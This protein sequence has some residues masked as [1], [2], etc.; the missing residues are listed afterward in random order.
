MSEVEIHDVR[1]GVFVQGRGLRDW[2]WNSVERLQ[3]AGATCLF[4]LSPPDRLPRRICIAR[5]LDRLVQSVLGVGKDCRMQ[6]EES[7]Q[8]HY[9]PSRTCVVE[10]TAEGA[11]ALSSEQR[12]RLLDRRLKFILFF[13]A[14]EVPEGLAGCAE[15]G[16]WRFTQS[17]AAKDYPFIHGLCR[18][19]DVVSF[20]LE[21]IAQHQGA[22]RPLLNGH[23]RARGER[24]RSVATQVLSEAARW[25]LRVLKHVLLNRNLP[26]P[27]GSGG[28]DAEPT[29]SLALIPS[30]LFRDLLVQMASK[31]T[32]YFVLETWTIGLVRMNF[33]A[34]L[35]GALP[36]QVTLLPRPELGRYIADPFI[37]STTPELTFLVEDYT[38]FEG[39]RISEVRVR[40]P[41]GIPQV[42]LKVCLQSR[43]H[44]SYPFLFR[45]NG[46]TYCLP[47][48]HQSLASV[49][50][51]YDAGEFAAVADL[52]PGA[53][54]TDA[55]I[56]VHEGLYW[57]F[58][59][60]ADDNDQANLHLFFS[61]TLRGEW[62]PHPLNPVKT[63]VRS[64]RSA[65]PIF[66]HDGK[67]FR[68]AQDCSRSYGYGLSINRI[69]RLTVTC[70][71]ETVVST[72]GPEIISR[73]CKGVHTFSFADNLMV[74]DAKFHLIGFAP[75]MVRALRRINRVRR[76]LA[77][78]VKYPSAQHQ[79]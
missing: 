69:D 12:L 7:D 38:V 2:E 35:D 39:G 58:C 64:S 44:M 8:Q 31:L 79:P 66:V 30:L 71:E 47:E 4:I 48:C 9:Q 57:L 50:Y 77:R 76:G 16:V 36:S 5:I 62:S 46:M 32:S 13:G 11:L 59:G 45:E 70:F 52:I 67:L 20:G 74:I 33:E 24:N 18:R 10:R 56:L 17:G 40:D 72:I 3:A 73:S 55:T 63:D 19:H 78:N 23:F 41:F 65:G 29:H 53:R 6:V 28:A 49:L 1:F 68:P 37:L 34:L 21:Q 42:D 25:P 27:P 43:Y 14:G 15:L 75:I 22:A 54:T 26:V 61:K 51:R 60:F